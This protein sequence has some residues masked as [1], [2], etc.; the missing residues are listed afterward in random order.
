MDLDSIAIKNQRHWD[1]EVRQR[2][3]YTQPWLNL[4]KDLLQAYSRGSV[5]QLPP[6]VLFMHPRQ[7]LLDVAGKRVLCLASGGGQQSAIFG[8]LG[9][10]V[11]V[12]DLC[13]GQLESDQQAARHYGYAVRT[14]QGDM[15]DLS[16]FPDASFDLVYQSISIVFVPD[17]RE[18]YFQAARVLPPGGT[19]FVN[20]CQP[21]TYPACFDGPNNGWDGV[22]YRLAEP[23]LGGPTRRKPDGSESMTEGEPTGEYRHLLS[24]IFNGLV[25]AGLEIRGVYEDPRCLT[26][27]QGCEPGSYEHQIAYVASYFGILTRKAC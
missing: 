7:L 9:A 20:H 2:K 8:L 16:Q 10:D 14:V 15:R 24:D 22:G 21:A 13:A 17:V 12:L 6:P 4:N 11:T 27:G 3:H 19:Y 18:V 23:Y 25:E 5:P 26:G 1:E